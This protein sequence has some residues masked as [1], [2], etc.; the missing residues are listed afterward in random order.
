MHDAFTMPSHGIIDVTTPPNHNYTTVGCHKNPIEDTRLHKSPRCR[1][2]ALE[3]VFLITSIPTTDPARYISFTKIFSAND[4]DTAIRAL[5]F[6]NPSISIPMS[7]KPQKLPTQG[8]F[9]VN[10]QAAYAC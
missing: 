3:P 4:R 2:T 9:G 10:K 1:S 6:L 8:I 7:Q 5:K